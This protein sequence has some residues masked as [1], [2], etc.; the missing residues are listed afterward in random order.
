[1]NADA[2]AGAETAAGR[3]GAFPGTFNPPTIAHLA[4]A[5]A[6]RE[7]HDL[8]RVDLVL[9]RA[10]IGKEHVVVPAFE[11]RLAVLARITE[12]L[13]WLRVVVTDHRLIV[14]IALGYDLVIMGADKWEQVNDPR[15]YNGSMRA[16][17][18]A[19]R[20]LPTLALFEREG[21][22]IPPTV[23]LDPALRSV[24]STSARRGAHH[25]MAPEARESG[26]WR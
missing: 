6:A 11:D 9:S 7:A 24:S 16:R 1:M 4:I 13:E 15:F 14:D 8:A 26:L 21:Y 23:D 20:R 19:L 10:P 2:D 18:E 22:D 17:D 3:V 5:E 12:R 25:L